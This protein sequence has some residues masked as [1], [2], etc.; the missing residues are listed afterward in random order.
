[1]SDQVTQKVLSTMASVKHIPQERISLEST[2][3]ELGVDSLDT[4]IMLSELEKEFG[5]SISD[6]E[7]RSVRNVRDI[8]EGVRRLTNGAA[9]NSAAAAE[10]G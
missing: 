3:Q 5:I 10:S 1:M 2:L 4:I 6:D 7:A 9:L 8:V